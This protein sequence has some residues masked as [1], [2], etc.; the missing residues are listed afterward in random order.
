MCG[1]GGNA[2]I[3]YDGHPFTLEK[4]IENRQKLQNGYFKEE[5]LWYL[6]WALSDVGRR[7]HESGYKV[8]DIT[9]RN[10]LM[11]EHGALKLIHQFSWPG[12]KTNYDRAL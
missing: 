1:S 9:P 11:N 7:F 10:V 8:G 3:T 6:L 12:N 5:E 2:K 4:E